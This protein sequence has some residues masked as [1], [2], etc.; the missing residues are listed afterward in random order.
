MEK[1]LGQVIARR[2]G[3]VLRLSRVDGEKRY[4]HVVSSDGTVS[5]EIN[6]D[7][8]L[9]RGYWKSASGS[10]TLKSYL[11]AFEYGPGK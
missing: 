8:V 11:K 5:P 10:E 4:G 1:K 9:S 6:V 7:S 3:D 2:G